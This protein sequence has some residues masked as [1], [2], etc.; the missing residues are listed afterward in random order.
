[1][2]VRTR[3]STQARSAQLLALGAEAFA[4]QGFD[5]VNLENI[6][7]RAGVTRTLLY[8]YFPTKRAFFLATMQATSADLRARTEPDMEL[9]PAERLRRGIDGFLDY[10][11][12]HGDT[13]RVLV[14]HAS[15]IDPEVAE[16]AGETRALMTCRILGALGVD[17]SAE[18]FHLA[19]FGWVSMVETVTL[20]WIERRVVDRGALRELLAGSLGAVLELAAGLSPGSLPPGALAMVAALPREAEGMA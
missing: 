9:A 6:A 8:H 15:G 11:E 7:E 12:A 10:I 20:R 18:L 2:A 5:A 16:V 17:A 1:M 3:L 13:F 4:S 19:V 14:E